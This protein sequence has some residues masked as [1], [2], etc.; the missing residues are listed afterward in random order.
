MSRFVGVDPSTKTGICV[1]NESGEVVIA[2]EITHKGRDPE[3]MY[4]IIEKTIDEIRFHHSQ[5]KTHVC[6]EGFSYGSKG[7]SVDIQY[8]IGWGL[9]LGMFAE[10]IGYTEVA[11]GQLKRFA[12][13]RGNA[14]KQYVA[15]ETYKRWGFESESDNITDAYVLAQIARAQNQNLPL[16]KFQHEVVSKLKDTA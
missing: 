8:G 3:R 13:G 5:N 4:N 2:R 6:I 1:L 10:Y 9:R 16:T 11:P 12:C 7:R 14:N 15:I